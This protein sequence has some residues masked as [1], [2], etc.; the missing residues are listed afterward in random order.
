MPPTIRDLVND[1]DFRGLPSQEKA[2]VMAE[3]F[4]DF[5]ELPDPERMQVVTGIESDIAQMFPERSLWERTTDLGSRAVGAVRDALTPPPEPMGPYRPAPSLLPPAIIPSRIQRAAAEPP[6]PDEALPPEVVNPGLLQRAGEAV[7]AVRPVTERLLELDR[8]ARPS[9]APGMEIPPPVETPPDVRNERTQF[10]AGVRTGA[11]LMN[12]TAANAVGVGN[13]LY[14]AAVGE[15]PEWGVDAERWL[16]SRAATQEEGRP[17]PA[18]GFWPAAA[19]VAGRVP[20]DLAQFALAVRAGGPA[21]AGVLGMLQSAD[22]GLLE[23]LKSGGM[24]AAFAQ[25]GKWLDPYS[26]PTRV[27]ANAGAAYG[28]TKAA[29]GTDDEAN[30]EAAVQALMALPGR[31]WSDRTQERIDQG[32]AAL[33]EVLAARRARIRQETQDRLGIPREVAD[34][35]PEAP[36]TTD[37]IQDWIMQERAKTAAGVT[38]PVAPA[39]E[40]GGG[41]RIAPQGDPAAVRAPTRPPPALGNEPETRIVLPGGDELPARYALVEA[42]ALLPSHNPRTFHKNEGHPA[43]GQERTY[44]DLD[45]KPSADRLGVVRIAQGWDADRLLIRN[46]LATDGP[47]IVTEEGIVLGGNKRTM[48]TLLAYDGE[49]GVPAEAVRQAM[50]DRAAAFGLDPARAAEFERPMIVRVI[51]DAVVPTDP[52]GLRVL[53]SRLNDSSTYERG[54]WEEASST[55]ARLGSRSMTAILDGLEKSGSETTSRKVMQRNRRLAEALEADGIIRDENRALF[56]DRQTGMLTNEGMDRIENAIV[57]RVIGSSDVLNTTQR[58]IINGLVRS[59]PALLRIHGLAPELKLPELITKA[60]ESER[61]RTSNPKGVDPIDIFLGQRDLFGEGVQS[62]SH[63]DPNV[64][65]VHR[66][67]NAQMGE[68]AMKR[69]FA[70]LAD[71]IAEAK[72]GQSDIFGGQPL[73][74]EVTLARMGE[75]AVKTRAEIAEAKAATKKQGEL[76]V[77]GDAGGPVV[78]MMQAPT[79]AQRARVQL[80]APAGPTGGQR[81][82]RVPPFQIPPTPSP[83][84]VTGWNHRPTMDSPILPDAPIPRRLLARSDIL[85]K[86]SRD[87]GARVVQGDLRSAAFARGRAPEGVEGFHIRPY[88][89]V[90]IRRWNDI[91]TASHELAHFLHDSYTVNDPQTGRPARLFQ[92]FTDGSDPRLDRDMLSTSYDI[93]NANEGFAEFVRLWMTQPDHVRQSVPY[94]VS[95]FEEALSRMETRHRR[96]ML[97]A[98]DEMTRYFGQGALGNLVETFSSQ[99][100]DPRSTLAGAGD[101]FRQSNVDDLHGIVNAFRRTH[102]LRSFAGTVVERAYLLRGGS[103]IPRGLI[104]FGVPRLQADGSMRFEGRGLKDILAP[105]AGSRR[106]MDRFFAYATARQARELM[107]QGRENL[108]SQNMIDAG[109]ALETPQYARV[110]ADLQDFQRRAADFGEATG[111]FSRAQRDAWTRTQYAWG[112]FRDMAANERRPATGGRLDSANPVRRLRGSSR[113][114]RHPLESLIEGPTR[115]IRAG[116]ENQVRQ[117][118]ADEIGLRPGGGRFLNMLAAEN[119]PVNVSPNQLRASLRSELI[120]NGM[121]RDQANAAVARFTAWFERYRRSASGAGISH[122]AITVFAPGFKPRGDDVMTVLRNGRPEYW[123]LTDPLLVRAVAAFHRPLPLVPWI[124]RARSAF[125]SG[126]TS[127]VDFMGANMARDPVAA[128]ILTKTGAQA[129]TTWMSG[130]KSVALKDRSFQDFLANLGGGGG[131]IDQN[132]G[133][134]QRRLVRHARRHQWDPRGIIVG[135]KD[136]ADLLL[137]I[138][139]SLEMASRVGEFKRARRQGQ[140]PLTSAHMGREIVTDW[141]RR[142]DFLTADGRTRHIARFMLESIPF[143]SAA[144]ASQDRLYR[145][146]PLARSSRSGDRV[147]LPGGIRLDERLSVAAKSA[148]Y[149]ALGL[150]AYELVRD[151]EEYQKLSLQERSAYIHFPRELTG[152]EYFPKVPVAFEFGTLLKVAER[153]MDMVRGSADPIERS[154]GEEIRDLLLSAVFTSRLTLPVGAQQA[155]EQFANRRGGAPIETEG[156]QSRSPYLRAKETTP[157]LPRE[158]GRLSKKAHDATGGWFPQISPVR[159]ES[160]AKSLFQGWADLAF[161]LSDRFIQPETRRARGVEEQPFFRR[162]VTRTGTKSRIPTEFWSLVEEAERAGNDIRTLEQQGRYDEADAEFDTPESMLT[163]QMRAAARAVQE[164][165][166]EIEDVLRDESLGPEERADRVRELTQERNDL[167]LEEILDA[168]ELKREEKARAAGGAR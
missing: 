148:A 18:P 143:F 136:A 98:Q 26:R 57:A 37:P 104:E 113:N 119:R 64:A 107:A 89:I 158:I 97:R 88:N 149:V 68:R 110:F 12:R 42:D 59:A 55:A 22:Q 130:L 46:V 49:G 73:S 11:A 44:H 94:A 31:R 117:R 9:E 3:L 4:P 154:Y 128:S 28:L 152:G 30:A 48:G 13:Q 168:Q 78:E 65:A 93:T 25:F 142:G 24:N 161:M 127:F 125:Q 70:T 15:F 133:A 156:M 34:R 8:W 108:I 103:E 67:I 131:L 20:F 10:E 27:A 159:F 66:V 106:Q 32:R 81:T 69:M 126:I 5:G 58:S 100:E 1:E 112:F 61:I 153:M 114:L 129:F 146:T 105:V 157:Q 54:R 116:L 115:M 140:H 144:I 60:L 51:P 147:R 85:F 164:I 36:Q 29:G 52:D 155:F 75:L 62:P 16:R 77:E 160:L 167:M 90:K 41:Q 95:R 6:L 102:G 84:G 124:N 135:P 120:D 39:P 163:D 118:I 87:L 122:D 101:F 17:D 92:R 139:G 80:S 137:S 132:P 38:D 33:D 150:A 74:P 96:A 166:G 50:I 23:A 79:R 14:R 165:Q 83:A 82:T 76:P 45:G 151:D 43:G 162:F 2:A 7:P 71:N 138:S 91:Q 21:G 123:Q 109:M 53:G 134:L 63:L 86:L 145:A 19:R 35:T 141:A 111:L 72:A 47:P 56:L 99:T 121:P 40:V